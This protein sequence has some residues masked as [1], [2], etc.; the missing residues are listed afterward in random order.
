[1]GIGASVILIAIGA[2]LEYAMPH[3]V[4]GVRLGS[5]GVIL[6][7]VGVLG[8]AVAAFIYGPRSRGAVA[9]TRREVEPERDVVVQRPAQ[10][11][12]VVVERESRRG[13]PW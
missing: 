7:I 3:S 13:R 10:E 9:P 2:I 11:P 8:L 6:M 12:D 1:V 5:I 4:G